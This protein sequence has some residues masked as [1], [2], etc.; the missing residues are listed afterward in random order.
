MQTPPIASTRK[1]HILKNRKFCC[2]ERVKTMLWDVAKCLKTFQGVLKCLEMSEDI[3]GQLQTVSQ[4]VLRLKTSCYTF[5]RFKYINIY[6]YI[7][8]HKYIHVDIHIYIHIY[9]YIHIY[10]CVYTYMTYIYI[11]IYIHIYICV[12]TYTYI[13]VYIYI[14]FIY[15][16][17]YI[18][19][20][21]ILCR[22]SSSSRTL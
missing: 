3:S 17:I 2:V 6:I 18:I 20:I 11:Y 7:Y 12:S 1:K 9:M 22:K 13:Y 8:I 19:F 10:I 15:V 5:G 14:I 21:V 16:Y 4:D